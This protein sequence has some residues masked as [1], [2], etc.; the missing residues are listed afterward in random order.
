MGIE[1]RVEAVKAKWKLWSNQHLHFR[2]NLL[3]L[4]LPLM[5]LY[6][7][8][9]DDEKLSEILCIEKYIDVE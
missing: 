3:D 1:E 7:K 4:S 5:F 9:D 2:R 6:F 8:I